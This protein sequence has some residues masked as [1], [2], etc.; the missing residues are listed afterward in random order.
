LIQTLPANKGGYE[1]TLVEGQV[2][3]LGD[4]AVASAPP[5]TINGSIW[6]DWNNDGVRD[7][8]D[9]PA[10]NQQVYLDLNDDGRY[11]TSE[12]LTG[13]NQFGRFIFNQ[14][15]P[16]EYTVRLPNP[17]IQTA[18]ANGAGLPISIA[19]GQSLYA[20]EFLI[21]TT[22]AGPSGAV[23]GMAWYDT[24]GDGVKG[25]DEAPLAGRTIY[26][27]S[28]NNAK[29][30]AYDAFAITD[31]SGVFVF[32]NR[33]AGQ[34]ILRQEIPAGWRATKPADNG[35]IIVPLASGQQ[36]GN[37]LFGSVLL[38]PDAGGPY[39]LV[40]GQS[41]GLNGSPAAGAD[42][43]SFDWSWDVNGDGVFADASG[44]SP[45]LSWQQLGDLGID[46]GPAIWNVRVRIGM[47]GHASTSP[48]TALVV[49]D[50]SPT[51]TLAEPHPALVGRPLTI[52]FA[53]TDAGADP[54]N[55]WLID[56]GDG[57]TEQISGSLSEASHSYE[58]AG[59]FNVKLTAVQDDGM[60]SVTTGAKVLT[61][62]QAVANLAET[63]SEM[64]VDP[65]SLLSKLTSASS[66]FERGNLAAA[67]AQ[68]TAFLNQ[69]DAWEGKKLTEDQAAGLRRVAEDLIV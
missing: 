33:S 53:A 31:S 60:L 47:S 1:V 50:V 42:P 66:G 3:R 26:V 59:E 14:V 43:Q 19:S 9:M 39:S 67:R 4:F 25:A 63:V 46:N 41:L 62:Q 65:Q 38:P 58:T 24:N 13:T 6:R 18:P 22:T 32:A 12:P 40:E 11:S 55:H 48:A 34:Y 69:V 27:D 37:H 16:G 2:L 28:E 52:T 8:S 20:G 61:P 35:S 36:S 10:I 51:I 21:R 49:A 68:V 56:W 29:R 23:S 7:A 57:F 17:A 30:D 45:T 44:L 15:V 5:G 54:V 64:L